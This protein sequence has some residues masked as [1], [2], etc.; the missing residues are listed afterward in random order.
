MNQDIKKILEDLYQ[1]D[2]SFKQHEE[3]LVSLI[4]NILKSKPDTKFDAAF[5]AQL[6]QQLQAKATVLS[7]KPGFSSLNAMQKIVY[8]FAGIAAIALIVF[9]VKNNNVVKNST[10]SQNNSSTTRSLFGDQ[11]IHK[12]GSNSFGS[13]VLTDNG[14]TL[15]GAGATGMGGGGGNKPQTMAAPQT[16]PSATESSPNSAVS[17]KMMAPIGGMGG[18]GVAG[19]PIMPPNIQY[20]YKYAGG[21]FTVPDQVTVYKKNSM[22]GSGVSAADVLKSLNFGL[23]DMGTF[24]NLTVQS[25]NLAENKQYGYMFYVD[26]SNNNISINQNWYQWPDPMRDCQTDACYQQN[27]VKISDIPADSEVVSIADSFLKDHNISTD[28][29]GKPVVQ[30]QWRQ[31]YEAAADKSQF[32]IPDVIS[33]VYP[34]QI[35][36]KT[37]YDEAGNETGL[38]VSV[39]IRFKKV[40]DLSN[41]SSLSFDASDYGAIT[42][43]KE[44]ISQAE[45]GGYHGVINYYGSSLAERK[46]IELDTPSIQLIAMYQYT[47]GQTGMLYVPSLVFPIKEIPKDQYFYKQNIIVPLVKGLVN[48]NPVQIMPMGTPAEPPIMK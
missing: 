21:D 42:G 8:L 39:N 5:A 28:H 22:T 33:V 12:V 17:P 14:G 13:L 37:V 15:S 2:S 35:D 34:L 25:F 46:T 44:L 24:S 38:M 30:N 29:F 45:N 4:E 20:T 16:A 47:D 43:T 3:A 10:L 23:V 18:G 32:Y 27:R 31:S 9:T 48:D 26:L 40:T 19:M 11:T 6:R 7:Q 1:L 36:G 41:L